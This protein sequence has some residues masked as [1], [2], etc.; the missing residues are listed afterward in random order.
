MREIKGVRILPIIEP[1]SDSNSVLKSLRAITNF[2]LPMIFIV[3]PQVGKL[4]D[5]S[6]KVSKLFDIVH[7]NPYLIVALIIHSQSSIVEI[8]R[9]FSEYSSWQKSLIHEYDLS[10]PSKIIEE[11]LKQENFAHHIFI[12]GK[13]GDGYNDQFRVFQRMQ[14]EDGFNREQVLRNADRVPENFYSDLHSTYLSK[15][16]AGF[17]DFTITGR[18]YSESKWA[19]YAV[20]IHLTYR[21]MLNSH[22]Q[23]RIMNFVSD[24]KV[25][26]A[27]VAGKYLEA[28][29]KLVSFARKAD[30][31]TYHST[32]V[33]EFVKTY[34][35]KRFPGLA[36]VKGWSIRHHIELMA[37]IIQTA[38]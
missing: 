14:I 23:I 34:K 35:E 5:E 3:N 19:A 17:G 18:Q 21:Q 31:P 11:C 28:V 2:Q 6:K 4:R 36:K 37:S 15:G 22:D 25:G 9:F 24:R 1:V 16:Y 29:T 12:V 27:D 20:A 38:D 33:E 26:T 13:T 8:K 32:A 30:S 10:M 7:S